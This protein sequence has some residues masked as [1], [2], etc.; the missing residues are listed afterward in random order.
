MEFH[1]KKK[2]HEIHLG[3]RAEIPKIASAAK[4]K[5]PILF[6]PGVQCRETPCRTVPLANLRTYRRLKVKPFLRVEYKAGLEYLA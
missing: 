3:S 5:I 1:S 6:T 2:I 4:T